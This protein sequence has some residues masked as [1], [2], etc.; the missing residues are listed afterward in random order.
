MSFVVKDIDHNDRE[1]CIW[2]EKYALPAIIYVDDVWDY[3]TSKRDGYFLGVF[4]DGELGGFGK[5]TRL[6]GD[7]GWLET[8]RVHPDYQEQG[9]GNELYI[10]YLKRAQE[11]RINKIGM[12]T[13]FD[14]FRSK[15]LAEKYGF[16]KQG[17][18]I[19]YTKDIDLAL[20]Y[21]GSFKLIENNANEI[22][23]PLYD[24]MNNYVI[25]NKTFFPAIDGLA[26]ELVKRKWAYQD[27]EGNFVVV[28]Y[29]MQPHKAVYLGFYWGDLEKITPFV[30]DLGKQLGSKRISAVRNKND[31]K[32]EEELKAVGFGLGEEIITMWR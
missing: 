13:E 9:F 19:D 32:V 16:S 4:R 12:F 20:D 26:D 18:F 10:E 6:F 7:I 21:Q 29:R 22:I 1:R 8:I 17:D 5:L 23:K 30:N 2:I 25:L 3:F 27:D 14:N 28:G 31:E 24:K 15:S 11:L